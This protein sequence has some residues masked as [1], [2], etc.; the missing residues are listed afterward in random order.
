MTFMEYLSAYKLRMAKRLLEETEM[1]VAAIAEK[2]D[3]SSAQNFIR[4][5]AKARG[6]HRENIEMFTRR[7]QRWIE[8]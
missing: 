7:K 8:P 5:S 2:L 6:L 4:F 3:Y 1:P